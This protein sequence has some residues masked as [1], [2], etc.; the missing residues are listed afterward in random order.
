MFH[1]SFSSTRNITFGTLKIGQNNPE[2][3]NLEIESHGFLENQVFLPTEQAETYLKIYILIYHSTYICPNL[4][5]LMENLIFK[6][7]VIFKFYIWDIR[8]FLTNF[9]CS[10]NN[11]FSAGKW[12]AKQVLKFSPLKNIGKIYIKN[13]NNFLL[14]KSIVIRDSF[15]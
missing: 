12:K 1:F 5:G 4:F 2:I 13:T 9:E 11:I 15:F 14:P 8:V 6:E 7:T 3:P 10:K